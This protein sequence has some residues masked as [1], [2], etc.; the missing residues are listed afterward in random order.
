MCFTAIFSVFFLV[1]ELAIPSS[2]LILVL[3][4]RKSYLFVSSFITSPP[5]IFYPF[6]SEKMESTSPTFT[7][8][9][10]VEALKK[11][12]EPIAQAITANA[13]AITE[14]R[15][16]LKAQRAPSPL[17]QTFNTPGTPELPN[18]RRAS[19]NVFTGLK[20]PELNPLAKV[21][22]EL[23]PTVGQQQQL[24][25]QPLPDIKE[26]MMGSD[27]FYWTYLRFIQK[28]E[29]YK[30]SYGANRP[31]ADFIPTTIARQLLAQTEAQGLTMAN[32][33]T[34]SED[35]IKKL[36]RIKLQAADNSEFRSFL[37]HSRFPRKDFYDPSNGYV[38]DVRKLPQFEADVLTYSTDFMLAFNYH[39]DDN[40]RVSARDRESSTRITSPQRSLSKTSHVKSTCKLSWMMSLINTHRWVPLPA[41]L[42]ICRTSSTA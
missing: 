6:F 18:P 37:E 15:D 36:F 32:F 5:P 21:S 28:H 34:L 41:T 39:L 38:W 17:D 42:R 11:V 14:L 26:Y 2:P 4:L 12:N 31:F 29:S 23:A 16:D 25:I 1:L 13:Q 19:M 22:K 24:F 7:L 8:E 10:L 33:K 30:N 3:R 27:F 35:K 9:M 20:A 40:M